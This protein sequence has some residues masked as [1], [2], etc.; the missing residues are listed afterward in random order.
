M[1]HS[2]FAAPGRPHNG[3]EFARQNL[4]VDSPKG[5]DIDMATA[6]NL[7]K[8]LSFEYGFQ[9]RSPMRTSANEMKILF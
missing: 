4:D 5:R 1:E 8:I 7:P 2:G 6:I 9:Q 3:N